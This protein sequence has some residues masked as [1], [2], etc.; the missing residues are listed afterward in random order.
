MKKINRILMLS[1]ILSTALIFSCKKDIKEA[2]SVQSQISGINGNWALVKAVMNDTTATTPD[3]VD[4]TDY[5]QDASKMPNINFNVTD[6][7]YTSDV[8]GVGYDFFGIGG[9]WAFDDPQY[10]TNITFTPQGGTPF[11]MGM[12]API[13][14]VDTR[15]KIQKYM[16][17][18]S[19][20][21]NFK[22][23]YQIELERR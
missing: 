10:P 22:F 4:V 5:F 3:P 23:A 19:A 17:C 16:Y 18:D 12:M 1:M 8:N 20:K 7:T 6:Y 2:A 11:T 13:R 15:L 14:I 21:T 9:K